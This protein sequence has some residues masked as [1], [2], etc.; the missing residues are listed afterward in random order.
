MT[1]HL[2]TSN[3]MKKVDSDRHITVACIQ[4]IIHANI[5]SISNDFI[6]KL[7]VNSYLETRLGVEKLFRTT[8]RYTT[9]KKRSR[10]RKKKE[11]KNE[12]K[13]RRSD[14]IGYARIISNKC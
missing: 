12:R 3:W 6:F 2:A 14:S 10:G 1:T 7:P 11:R 4:V 9:Y 5:I 8:G 13:I